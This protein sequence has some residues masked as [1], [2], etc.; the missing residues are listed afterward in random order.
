M[1][2]DENVKAR[3]ARLRRLERVFVPVPIYFVTTNASN[4]RSILAVPEI[5]CAFLE[6]ARFGEFAWC[7]WSVRT[8]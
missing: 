8:F 3:K 6:F 4:R 5:H 1:T 7:P 2:A